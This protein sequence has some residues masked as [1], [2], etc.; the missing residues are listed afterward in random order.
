MVFVISIICQVDIAIMLA[1]S[2]LSIVVMSPTRHPL[3]SSCLRAVHCRCTP[4]PIT[5]ELSSCC[6]LLSIAVALKVHRRCT[7]AIPHCPSLSRSWGAVPCRH[8]IH[9]HRATLFITVESPSIAIHCHPL[10]AIHLLLLSCRC[11]VHCCPL[12]LSPL[13]LS[14]CRAVHCRPLPTGAA[15]PGKEEDDA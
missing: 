3:P 1:P 6:P 10:L 11:V 2:S 9:G 13:L 15:I 5:I 12:P 7:C 8:S 4:L 14:C